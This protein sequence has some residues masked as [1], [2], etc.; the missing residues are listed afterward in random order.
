[1]NTSCNIIVKAKT[2]LHSFQLLEQKI[3]GRI[4]PMLGSFTLTSSLSLGTS[5]TWRRYLNGT[6][7]FIRAII[8]DL[9]SR[10]LY[11]YPSTT[12]E[13]FD[14]RNPRPQRQSCEAIVIPSNK[15]FHVLFSNAQPIHSF[16]VSRAL[17][18]RGCFFNARDPS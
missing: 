5:T 13:H 11:V 7:V 2:H 6:H 8:I 14:P 9:T 12:Q 16:R 17:H 4:F 3:S 1:M 10:S 15:F 18:L